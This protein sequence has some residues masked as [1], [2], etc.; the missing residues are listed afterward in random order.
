MT[1]A[2]LALLAGVLAAGLS[3]GA[4]QAMPVANLATID[5]G[6]TAESARWVCGP[7]RCWWRPSRFYYGGP[8][9]YYGP[10]FYGGPR[11]Y[12]PRFYRGGPYW[13]GYRR[14]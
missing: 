10:R 5:T 2:K 7:Y 3:A 4:A 6:A 8:Y 1:K 11:F 9:A 12:V 14:W 13:R